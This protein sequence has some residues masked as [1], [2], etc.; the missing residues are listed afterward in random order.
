MLSLQYL[1]ISGSP[2]QYIVFWLVI[3]AM[4][5]EIFFTPCV[6]TV[7]MISHFIFIGQSQS[8]DINTSGKPVGVTSQGLY[9][10]DKVE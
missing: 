3:L 4:S 7:L 5:L 1:R 8:D 10:N 9:Y 6:M 2:P